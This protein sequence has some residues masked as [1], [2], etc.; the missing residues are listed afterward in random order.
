MMAEK[1]K[2]TVKL[3]FAPGQPAT[4]KHP[5]TGEDLSPSPTL[6]INNGGYARL[7]NAKDQPFEAEPIEEAPFL[8]RTGYF[9]V[10][11]GPPKAKGPKP[12]KENQGNAE[13][14]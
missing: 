12:A 11:D 14:S 10:A 5:T 2:E 7:F 3:N 8:L 13:N 6:D 1:T 4:G 9:V